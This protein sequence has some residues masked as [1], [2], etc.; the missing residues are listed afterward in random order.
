MKPGHKR[1]KVD[2]PYASW[3]GLQR[4]KGRTD[5]ARL[6]TLVALF[7]RK[8]DEIEAKAKTS[9]EEARAEA[10]ASQKWPARA[11][12]WLQGVFGK[13]EAS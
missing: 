3:V 12:R 13:V 6:L 7:N 1:V 9:L 2:I 8:H 5:E 10:I 4:M 11:R